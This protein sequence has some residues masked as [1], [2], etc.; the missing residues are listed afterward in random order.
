LACFKIKGNNYSKYLFF[1]LKGSPFQT[2]FKLSMTGMIGGV[3]ISSINNF[4]LP[5]PPLSEQ[6]K[7]AQFLDDK[8]SK[9]DVA[10]TIK[11]QQI[12]LLKERKQIL[13][14]KAVTQGLNSNVTLKDS[15]VEWIGK[16]PKHW[17]VVPLRHIGKTQNGLSKGGEYFGSGFPFLT[18]GDVYK[19]RTVPNTLSGLAEASIADRQ[20]FSIKEG[21]IF[22][23]RTSETV[24]DI[25]FTST[26]LNNLENGTFA[27]FLIRFRPEKNILYKGFSRYYFSS[28]THRSFFVGQ[29]NLV[30]RAS[31]SQDHLKRMP[32]LIPPLSE[33]KR[34]STYIE[35]GSQKIEIAISLKQQEIEKLKE[36]KSTLINSVVT[37]KVKVF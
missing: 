5:L 15:G 18:Y 21:D 23:T 10:V 11:E 29:M 31:L 13:I 14:H 2:Q 19:N 8:T 30:I 25:A 35:T 24:E 3:S 7:I 28:S 33:Q 37:G 9:I 26:C 34:I 12:N 32:V 4:C 20:Q 1:S 6:T 16:I 27:G 17:E 36:Y 22:F